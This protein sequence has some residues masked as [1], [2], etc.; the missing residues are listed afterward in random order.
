[1]K[2]LTV[3]MRLFPLVVGAVHGVEALVTAKA[4]PEKQDAAV[5]MIRAMAATIDAGTGRNL[6]DDPDIEKAVRA[7]IDVYVAL[8]N[9]ITRKVAAAPAS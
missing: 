7:M 4:G 9:V 1:M 5:I 3:T 6:L 2:W 8:H